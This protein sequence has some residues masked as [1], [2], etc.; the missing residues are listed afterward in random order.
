MKTLIET[1][2]GRVVNAGDVI[3]LDGTAHILTDFDVPGLVGRGILTFACVDTSSKKDNTQP[4][5]EVNETDIPAVGA[6]NSMEDETINAIVGFNHPKL[7]SV[8]LNWGYEKKLG[9]KERIFNTITIL[10]YAH[11]QSLLAIALKEL[12]K[13]VNEYFT[14]SPG[15]VGYALSLLDFSIVPVIHDESVDLDSALVAIFDSKEAALYA[16]EVCQ[17]IIDEL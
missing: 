1:K 9:T 2:T 4:T 7:E 5:P 14:L 16:K 15:Q 8:M 11:P 6:D 12:S 17:E 3:T 13:E 10:W